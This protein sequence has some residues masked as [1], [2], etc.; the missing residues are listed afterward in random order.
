MISFV[1][2]DLGGV[3]MLDFS[4]TDKWNQ[5]ESDLGLNK[6]YSKIFDQIWTEYG[7][8]FNYCIDFDIDKLIPLIEKECGIKLPERYSLLE[9]M[10]SRFEIN[11]SIWPIINIIT[12][13]CRIGLITNMYPRMFGLIKKRNILPPVKW[14]VI[15]DSSKIGYQ[16]PEGKIFEIAQEKAKVRNDEILFVENSNENI[17]A[18]KKFGWQTFLYDS[19]K[20]VES[21]RKLLNYIFRL[22][23]F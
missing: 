23:I 1:Y 21:S 20:P 4:G 10:V 22:R 17:E 12:K 14:D 9:D 13:T 2:F 8:K 7:N 5:L 6:K 19:T 15:I 3:V 11:A 18:A 16:K